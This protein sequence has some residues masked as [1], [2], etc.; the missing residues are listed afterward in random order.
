MSVT[1]Y[2]SLLAKVKAT[3]VSI[4]VPRSIKS[5]AML[6]SCKPSPATVTGTKLKALT[7]GTIK[8]K[9]ITEREPG[10]RASEMKNSAKALAVIDN[11][12]NTTI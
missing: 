5:T 7:K 10:C 1:V 12:V 4:G 3:A 2:N 11:K 9:L 8:K 6:I